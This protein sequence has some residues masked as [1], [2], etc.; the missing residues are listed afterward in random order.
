[1]TLCLENK[2]EGSTNHPTTLMPDADWQSP[3]YAKALN[4]RV[5]FVL[6]AYKPGSEAALLPLSQRISVYRLSNSPEAHAIVRFLV[7]WGYDTPS[8]AKAPP[9][10]VE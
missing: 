3:P 10:R 4:R 2:V 6:V 1:M 7:P 8:S 9:A 5:S